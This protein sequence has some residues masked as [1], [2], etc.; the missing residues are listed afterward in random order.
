MS[1]SST[2]RTV[3]P[4]PNGSG[5]GGGAAGIRRRKGGKS[6][7]SSGRKGAGSERAEFVNGRQRSCS[8]LHYTGM[9]LFGMTVGLLTGATVVLYAHARQTQVSVSQAAR[10]LF[11]ANCQLGQICDKD[12]LRPKLEDGRESHAVWDVPRHHMKSKFKELQKVFPGIQVTYLWADPVVVYFDNALSDNDIQLMLNIATPRFSPSTIVQPDG[13][14]KPD[15]GRTSDTA[16]LHF[17]HYD[18][19]VRFPDGK[20]HEIHDNIGWISL[21]F[22]AMMGHWRSESAWEINRVFVCFYFCF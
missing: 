4:S 21:R 11:T 13:S 12:A 7:H 1:P 14:S 15:T 20:L 19:Q 17:D 6:P 2:S 22:V 5:S 18:T 9:F 10:V 8:T 3:S 16:W